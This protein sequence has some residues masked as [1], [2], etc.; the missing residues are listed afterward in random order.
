MSGL[1]LSYNGLMANISTL[2]AQANTLREQGRSAEALGKYEQAQVEYLTQ[3]NLEFVVNVQ[4]EKAIVY[5]HLY[6]A[7]NRSIW[8]AI[9]ADHAVA[10]AQAWGERLELSV[11]QVSLLAFHQGET[12][13]MRGEYEAAKT[14][15]AQAIEILPPD[16][17]LIGNHRAHLALAL[18]A[19]GKGEQ[20]LEVMD[21]A[22]REIASQT[23]T[24]QY[25]KNVWISGAH[26]R[27][28]IILASLGQTAAA[29]DALNQAS[30]V[31]EAH[32]LGVRRQQ[33]EQLRST[34]EIQPFAW[35]EV[36]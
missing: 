24:D 12:K 3:E 28:A 17:Y 19:T 33:L 1:L 15:F 23:Q 6:Q 27:L 11:E 18:A 7:T 34:L 31:I 14:A 20:A 8:Y 16:H 10:T 5:K 26:L 21:L 35:S 13:L 9:L 30:Q 2:H 22:L 32:D 36:L 4:L 29:T 25:T